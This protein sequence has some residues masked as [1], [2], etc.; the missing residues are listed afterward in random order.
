MDYTTPRIYKGKQPKSLPKGTKLENV[1]AKNA[2]CITYTFNGKQRRVKDGLNRIKD[3]KE[4]LLQF[5]LL[6]KSIEN[7][8]K[9]GFDPDKPQVYYQKLLKN[10]IS[11]NKAIE[12]YLTEKSLYTRKKSGQSYASKLRHLSKE[13]PGKKL[14]ELT[15]KE[16]EHYI[17]RKINNIDNDLMFI[18]GKWVTINKITKWS[19]KTTKNARRVFTGFF[20]WCMQKEQS[21]VSENPV[22]E[23]APLNIRS[24]NEPKDTNIPYSDQDLKIVMDYLDEN[25]PYV[26]FFCRLIYYTLLRPGEICK[27]RLEHLNKESKQIK[28]P[29]NVM[30]VTRSTDPDII[31]ISPELVELLEE[32]DIMDLPKSFYLISTDEKRIS[33]EIPVLNG[34]IYKRLIKYLKKLNMGDKGYTLYGF[35]HTSNI[36]RFRNDWG[37]DE[38]M[39]AN[40]HTNIKT[41]LEYLKKIT[42]HVNISDKAIPKL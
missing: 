41:T 30:K 23:I 21:F 37:L 25:D 17:K 34:T 42:K 8:L 15:A 9:A 26:A 32:K 35:K 20:N 29:L 40:R 28:I 3:P 24:E 19:P 38:L 18:N 13:F 11:L 1:L 33:G 6:R 14:S 39:A 31:K 12:Q 7:D 10:E 4:K 27:L 36:N 2:W 5:E 16:I 22:K